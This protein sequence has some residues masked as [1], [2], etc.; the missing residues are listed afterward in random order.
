[1]PKDNITEIPFRPSTFETIDGAVYEYIDKS[2]NLHSTT[3]EGWKRVPIIWVATERSYQIKHDQDLR[4]EEGT[5]ILPAITIQRTSVVKDPAKRGG[6]QHHILPGNLGNF[7]DIAKRIKQDKTA[8]FENAHSDFLANSRVGPQF[9]RRRK[10]RKTVYEVISAPIPVWVEL[11]YS[12]V[13]RTEYQQQMNELLQPFV[14]RTGNINH[15]VISKDG[16]NF[17]SFVQPDFTSENN[18]SSMETEERKYETKVDIKVLGYLMGEG[19]NQDQPKLIVRET[20]VEFRLQRE[21]VITQP[22]SIPRNDG[23]GVPDGDKNRSVDGG[24][25]E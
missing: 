21:R 9:V 17:E 1:M 6:L 14:T 15:F 3:N 24:Y 23:T 5:L 2:F 25:R 10:N 11:T 7:F 22:L 19:D 4:D 13:L 16:H 18:T 20:A 8:E 12:I